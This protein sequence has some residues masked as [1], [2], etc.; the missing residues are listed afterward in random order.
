MCSA[1]IYTGACVALINIGADWM[2]NLFKCCT[3]HFSVD[4]CNSVY[5]WISADEYCM[6]MIVC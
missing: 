1:L 6:Y 4:T 3:E 5:L 2:Y